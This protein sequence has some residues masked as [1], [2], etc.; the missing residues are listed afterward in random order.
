MRIPL[1]RQ[2]F[3]AQKR[4]YGPPDQEPKTPYLSLMPV[5]PAK[6]AAKQAEA[7]PQASGR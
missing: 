3:A 5:M 2:V 7:S 4:G 1:N 6:Q